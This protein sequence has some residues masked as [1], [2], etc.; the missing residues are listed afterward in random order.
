[1]KELLQIIGILAGPGIFG[2]I[3]I[4]VVQIRKALDKRQDTKMF[5]LE[6]D[7]EIQINRDNNRHELKVLEKQKSKD[8]PP[9]MSRV[10]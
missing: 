5:Q 4:I 10:K 6:C 3:A 9:P 7:K 8:R 1:M 2:L